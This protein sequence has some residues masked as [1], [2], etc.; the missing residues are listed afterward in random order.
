MAKTRSVRAL[1]D[2]AKTNID[3][4]VGRYYSLRGRV[5]DRPSGIGDPDLRDRFGDPRADMITMEGWIVEFFSVMERAQPKR[6]DEVRTTLRRK[7]P[8]YRE[9][10]V[11]V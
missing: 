10:R 8:E 4:V 11:D 5:F 6:G 9:G 3:A 1:A 2:A 7:G